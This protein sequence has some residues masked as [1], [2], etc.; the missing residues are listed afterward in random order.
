LR[1]LQIFARD[2]EKEG[3][4]KMVHVGTGVRIPKG[5]HY[6]GDGTVVKVEADRKEK[7]RMGGLTRSDWMGE[8]TIR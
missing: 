1:G 5:L 2:N 4:K 7:R 3:K 6:K 8:A